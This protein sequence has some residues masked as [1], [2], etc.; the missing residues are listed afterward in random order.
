MSETKD[1]KIKCFY[2]EIVRAKPSKRILKHFIHSKASGGLW[3]NIRDLS[4]RERMSN[5]SVGRQTVICIKVGYNPKL[6][7]LWEQIVILDE[8]GKSYNIKEKPDEY[9]Y[10]KGDIKITAYAFR[11]ENLYEGEIYD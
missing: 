1:K 5:A 2:P 4:Q 11:D 3:C 7:E 8:K 10:D 9:Y 6:I